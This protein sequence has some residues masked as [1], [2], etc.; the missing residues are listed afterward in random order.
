M[1]KHPD[2]ERAIF[3][4]VSPGVFRAYDGGG[5][6]TGMVAT[7]L[8]SD[9]KPVLIPTPGGPGGS[10]CGATFTNECS[11][12]SVG[13]FSS[14]YNTVAGINV[15]DLLTITLEETAPGSGV[16]KYSTDAF[17]PIDGELFGNQNFNA[18][19]PSFTPHNY[20]FT[21]ELHNQ[22]TYQTG[23]TFSFSGDDDLW[24]FING[25]LVIDLGGT[26]T[27][28]PGTV[29]LDALGLTV[30]GTYGLDLFFAERHTVASNF[31]ITTSIANIASDLDPIPEPSSMVLL[32]SGLVGLVAY[33]RRR[34]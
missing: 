4:Q 34:R 8:G 9:G 33:R 28:L 2:F 11:I 12:L 14:W 16:F 18:G 32:G 22:F 20:H 27:A 31:T 7:T 19:T 24:V 21:Y 6:K 30:G 17:F 5:L 25:Q 15:A 1:L 26:H 23:Q 13:S 10:G 29:N 3:V